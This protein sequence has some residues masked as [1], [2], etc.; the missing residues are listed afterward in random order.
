MQISASD[1]FK[2]LTNFYT[3]WHAIVGPFMFI[4]L[5]ICFLISV[6]LI[7]DKGTMNTQLGSNCLFNKWC[8]WDFSGG[9][10][11]NAG[12]QVQSLVM[13]LRSH[14]PQGQKTKQNKKQKQHCNKFNKYFLNGPH[15]KN[16]LKNGVGK[17]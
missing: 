11:V 13:E 6:Q 14:M 12:V 15:Q 4:L 17:T 10:V 9:P 16:L 3:Y 8:G 1:F 7:F 5:E 2:W